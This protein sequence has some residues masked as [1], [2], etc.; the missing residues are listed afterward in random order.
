MAG[1]RWIGRCGCVSG[2]FLRGVRDR[3]WADP[4]SSLCLAAA[5]AAVGYIVAERRNRGAL[6]DVTADR[7]EAAV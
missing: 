1:M 5:I 7:A 6:S 4:R 3:T 2:I